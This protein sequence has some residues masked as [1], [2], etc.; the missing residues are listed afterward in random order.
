MQES[1][2]KHKKST[3]ISDSSDKPKAE[4]S[5]HYVSNP[6]LLKSF[7]DWYA[8]LEVAE[9]SGNPEPPM[10]NKIGLAFLQIA[11]NLAKKSN[12]ISNTKWKEEM[13]GDAV[14]N[15]IRYARNFNPNITSNPFAYFTQIS[16]YAF[17]RRIKVEKKEDYIKHKTMLNSM[18]Y[19]EALEQGDEDFEITPFDYN[20]EGIESFIKDFEIKNFGEELALDET[21]GVGGKRKQLKAQKEPPENIGFF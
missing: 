18:I 3:I 14:E 9:K 16:Y 11:N 6:D 2:I 1:E 5:K 21:A 19:Q 4:K 13:V 17:L 20:Q 8:A 15:C 7:K 12:W 10:P